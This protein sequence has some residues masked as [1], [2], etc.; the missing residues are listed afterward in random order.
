[1][2]WDSL[3]QSMK[4]IPLV[5]VVPNDQDNSSSND[6]SDPNTN[7][8]TTTTTTRKALAWYTCGPTTYSTMHLGHARTYVWLDMMRR[9]LE[10]VAA[11]WDLMILPI[12]QT[13]SE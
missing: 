13:D 2:L 9:V 11:A 5:V 7:K 6:C 1:M 3:S 8:T 10:S 4:E 12:P